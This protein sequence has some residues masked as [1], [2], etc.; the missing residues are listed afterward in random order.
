MGAF[1]K[2]FKSIASTYKHAVFPLI[3]APRRL[4]YFETFKA[5]RLLENGT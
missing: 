4:F 1:G 2:Y 5:G 3:S